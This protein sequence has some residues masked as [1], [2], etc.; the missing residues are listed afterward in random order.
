MIK[1]KYLYDLQEI[2]I[3]KP[4]AK[5][6]LFHFF[7]DLNKIQY[8]YKKNEKLDFSYYY[9]NDFYE[10]LLCIYE[11]LKVKDLA[12]SEIKVYKNIYDDMFIYFS[13]FQHELGFKEFLFILNENNK[14]NLNEN[15]IT[16][17]FS[18]N[19]S[20]YY[21]KYKDFEIALCNPKKIEC[22]CIEDKKQYKKSNTQKIEFN[23]ILCHINHIN[24]QYSNMF[25]LKLF[26]QY[27]KITSTFNIMYTGNTFFTLEYKNCYYSVTIDEKII[28]LEQ[29]LHDDHPDN[30]LFEKEFIKTIKSENLK[31]INYNEI[32]KHHHNID[33]TQ[34]EKDI[35][36]D[37]EQ[38][39]FLNSSILKTK[40][41]FDF[42][43]KTSCLIGNQYNY[44]NIIKE[45][46]K[47][48]NLKILKLKNQNS[49]S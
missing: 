36:L 35:Y 22:Y 21:N 32:Q 15:S 10:N 9:K 24:N 37:K 6:I 4:K 34:L 43:N 26:D 23:N 12:S 29:F 31:I 8:R 3:N 14:I 30:M 41:I 38:I 49:I 18:N 5:K 33:I 7:N 42:I 2:N 44:E 16:Y 25:Y 47:I 46:S 39:D 19:K 1:E 27:N 13:K 48:M 45:I 11:Y 28:L 40:D 17:M 20:K